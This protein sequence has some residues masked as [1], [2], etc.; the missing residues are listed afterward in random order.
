MTRYLAA[1][2]YRRNLLRLGWSEADLGDGGSDALVDAIVAWGD[3]DA[4]AGRVR[5]HLDRGADH[6][7]VLMLGEDWVGDLERLAGVL[8]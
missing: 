1:D 4:V 6:V 2:N 7:S 8:W 5:E 3:A